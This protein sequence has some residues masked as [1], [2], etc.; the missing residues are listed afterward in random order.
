MNWVTIIWSMTA[1]ASLTL[2]GIHGFVWIRQPKRLESLMFCI[3][4][5]AT[6]GMAGCELL[7]M[8]VTDLHAYLNVLQWYNLLRWAVTISLVG[9]IHF[10]LASGRRWLEW[11]AIGLRTASMLSYWIFSPNI[12]YSSVESLSRIH[13]LGSEITVVE[14]LPS[15]LSMLGQISHLVLAAYI[16]DATFRSARKEHRPGAIRLGLSAVFFVLALS[17]QMMMALWTSMDMPIVAS[18]FFAGILIVMGIELSEDMLRSAQLAKALKVRESELLGERKITDAIFES[19]PGMLYLQ[20][21]DGSMV[22]WNSQHE[23]VTG[24]SNDET[25]RMKAEDFCVEAEREMLIEAR[26]TALEKGGHEV[27]FDLARR[28]GRTARHFFRMVPVEVTGNPHLVGIGIDISSQRALAAEAEKQREQMA[29]IARVASVSE[30]SSSLAHEI[31][32]PLAII[33][34]NAQAAQ[35]LVARENPDLKELCEILDD[36]VSADIRAADVI[37]RLRSILRQGKPALETVSPPAL[38]DQVLSMAQPDLKAAGIQV[39]RRHSKKLPLIQADRIPV[40]QVLL[41]LVKNACEA[42]EDNGS[43]EKNLSLTCVNE[44]EWLR[45]S[46]RD[47][48]HGLVE[49]TGKIFEAFHTTKPNGLG[50]GLTICQTIIRAHGGNLW[51]EA[52]KT[53]GATFHFQLPVVPENL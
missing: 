23:R 1:A 50:L 42:M 15:P 8:H 49:P 44:G 33:L 6:A 40:E 36:I 9:F 28:D 11:T 22:R 18:L 3:M 7:S 4:A 19:A 16:M 34:S 17:I 21:A 43:R 45:F 5:V 2:A 52:N 20:A 31:N 46:V 39:T 48:G 25:S 29:H 30:L 53:H 24:F 32:Q 13:F 47:N 51:A 10:Y 26:K 27:E 14:G 41:N 37:K 12:Y 35:R 38:F